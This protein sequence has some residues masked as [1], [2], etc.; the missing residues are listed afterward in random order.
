MRRKLNSHQQNKQ[1]K[2]P[3]SGPGV[4]ALPEMTTSPSSPSSWSTSGPSLYVMA[5]F[6]PPR[7]INKLIGHFKFSLPCELLLQTDTSD[8]LLMLLRVS[9]PNQEAVATQ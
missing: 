3:G 8:L 5:M 7:C 2:D 4:P 6:L 1:Q 9:A